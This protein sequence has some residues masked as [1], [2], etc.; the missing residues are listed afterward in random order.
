VPHFVPD[1]STVY[2]EWAHLSFDELAY[3]IA[4][5]YVGDEIPQKDL[6]DLMRRR[7]R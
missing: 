1:V 7:F 6:R 4:K 2:K 3:E 5:F